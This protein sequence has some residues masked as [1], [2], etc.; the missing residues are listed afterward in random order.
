MESAYVCTM[1]WTILGLLAGLVG[2]KIVD[3]RGQGF[4]LNITLRIVGAVGGGFLFD[5][6]GASGVATLN[7][8]SAMVAIVGSRSLCC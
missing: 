4:P 1:S 7:F 3:K 8:W 2:S 6:F 5:L